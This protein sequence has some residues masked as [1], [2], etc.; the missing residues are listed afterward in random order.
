MEFVTKLFRDR[1]LLDA[2]Q[3]GLSRDRVD[4]RMKRHWLH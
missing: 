1:N 4:G 2:I 3:L